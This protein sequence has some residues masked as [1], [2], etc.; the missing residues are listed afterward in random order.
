[1]LIH[2]FSHLVCIYKNLY[3]SISVFLKNTKKQR[4][5][6]RITTLVYRYCN[7]FLRNNFRFKEIVLFTNKIYPLGFIQIWTSSAPFLTSLRGRR[8]LRR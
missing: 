2:R 5:S 6:K 7:S 3:K 8:I 4:Y 1:M